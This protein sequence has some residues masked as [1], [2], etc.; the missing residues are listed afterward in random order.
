MDWLTWGA[1]TEPPETLPPEIP[2]I[3]GET[4]GESGT[5][6]EYIFSTEDPELEET[7]FYVEWGDDQMEEWIGPYDSGEEVTLSHIWVDD[8]SYMIKAKAKDCN[9]EESDWSYL[10]VEIPKSTDF[11][12][13]S[14]THLR[15]HET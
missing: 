6:Y 3:D 8:G 12:S 10:E 2:E 5:E 1:I 13:V 14:Y 11:S 4:Q 7:Y 9:G 15:A